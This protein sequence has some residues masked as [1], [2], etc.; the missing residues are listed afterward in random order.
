MRYIVAIVMLV[1]ALLFIGAAA[2]ALEK[3]NYN[4][5]GAF[6]ILSATLAF[7]SGFMVAG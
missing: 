1:S 5:F 7:L 3:K 6:S 2:S 4:A